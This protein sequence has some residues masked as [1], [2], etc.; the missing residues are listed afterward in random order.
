MAITEKMVL[1]VMSGTSLDGVDLAL[2]R[3]RKEET[4]SYQTFATS[5]Q[6]YSKKWR[7]QL[8]NCAFLSKEDLKELDHAY[9]TYLGN[10]IQDFLAQQEFS[11][12]FISSHGHTALHQP[13]QGITYQLGNLPQLAKIIGH[14]VICD[15][16]VGD[17]A[18]NGQGAPLV[19][20]GE[21]HLFNQYKACVN[22]GG[23]ANV[24]RLDQLPLAAYDI[25]PVNS[26]MNA[27][28]KPLGIAYDKGGGLARSGTIIPALLDALNQLAFY[29]KSPPKSLGIE[30]VKATVFPMLSHF[31]DE[32]MNDL[33]HS[34]CHHCAI[35]IAN[36]L[37]ATGKVLFSGGGSYNTFLMELIDHYSTAEIVVP[38][39]E[40]IEFKEAII[41]AFLGVLRELEL[42]NCL[43]SVTG[44]Q[45]DH[46]SGNIFLP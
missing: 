11:P 18:L 37:P 3:F 25:C 33:L 40:V 43:A 41:F 46:T 44:A 23:F 14:K 42:P 36:Q 5:T 20:S 17:V 10:V 8:S 2:V 24:S 4:W 38:S 45:F 26:V 39:S 1:G 30:W 7:D 16:R 9:T 12:D 6:P 34:F 35:Q 31:K 21:V 22:L 19:P 28:V 15:F 13:D 27:L 32:S 29:S